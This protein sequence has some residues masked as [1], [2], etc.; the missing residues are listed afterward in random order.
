MQQQ[1]EA[2]GIDWRP[3]RLGYRGRCWRRGDLAATKEAGGM[4]VARFRGISG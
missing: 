1:I 4:L 2:A 3:E